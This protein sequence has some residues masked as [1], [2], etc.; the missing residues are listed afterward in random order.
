MELENYSKEKI[1]NLLIQGHSRSAEKTC[2]YIHE[3]KIMFDSGIATNI[4]PNVLLLTHT[5]TDHSYNLPKIMYPL[6]TNLEKKQIF[7][8]AQSIPTIRKFIDSIRMMENCDTYSKWSHRYNLIGAI[9]D[10]IY[11]LYHTYEVET[12]RCYHS[13]P[14]LGYGILDKR[15]KLKKEFLGQDIG[16]L[17]KQPDLY[18]KLFE[19]ITIPIICYLG[20]TRIDV[21]D[22]PKLKK[23]PVIFIECTYLEEEM[24]ENARENMHINWV[25]LKP[26]INNYVDTKFILIHFSMRYKDSYIKEFFDNEI[27]SMINKNIYVWLDSGVVSY[28]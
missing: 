2:F 4:I 11:P 25:E 5:H 1:N 8:P 27:N 21:F 7:A 18:I 14:C 6:T 24:L 20:D 13:I 16:K 26:W 22:N 19:E 28:N 9:S 17:K 15:K 23:Y 10:K 12:F 3:L